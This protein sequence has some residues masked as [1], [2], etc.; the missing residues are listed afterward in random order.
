MYI[1]NSPLTTVRIPLQSI[2]TALSDPKVTALTSQ[3]YIVQFILPI[4][5]LNEQ[6]ALVFL[7][8]RNSQT[9]IDHKIILLFILMPLL[10]F[11]HVVAWIYLR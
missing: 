3:G 1:N 11:V 5:D 2:D 8:L 6:Y 4:E 7:Q 9:H 10:Q